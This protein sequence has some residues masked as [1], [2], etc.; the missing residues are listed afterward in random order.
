M[1]PDFHP[2]H[3]KIIRKPSKLSK[4]EVITRVS[5]YFHPNVEWSIIYNSQEV[6]ATQVSTDRRMDEEDMTYIQ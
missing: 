6:E 4:Q 1:P 2:T 5:P 3:K